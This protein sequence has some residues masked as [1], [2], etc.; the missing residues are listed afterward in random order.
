VKRL[1]IIVLLF[2]LLGFAGADLQALDPASAPATRTPVASA[3]DHDVDAVAQAAPPQPARIQPG[4]PDVVPILYR[5]FDWAN[6]WQNLRPEYGPVGSIHFHMWDEVNPAPGVYDWDVIDYWLAEESSL[7]VTLP[8]G[9]EIPKPVVIQVFPYI[10]SACGWENVFFYDGTPEWVYDQI[11]QENPSNPRPI[12]N[13]RKVGYKLEGCGDLV[14]VMPMYDSPTW[15]EA[16]FDLVRAFGERY[17]DHPQV[18][19]VVINTGLDGE[20]QPIKDF[21]CNWN[22]LLDTQLPGGVRYRFGQYL[23]QSMDVYRQAFPDK[24]IFINNAPGGGGTRQTT[25]DYAATFD[26]PIGLKHSGMWVDLDSHQGYGSFIGSWDMV[27]EYSQTLPIWL[28]SPYGFGSSEV[29][30]WALLAGLHYH[31]D[32]VDL[33]PDFF[34]MVPPDKLRWAGQH[35]GVTIQ[36]TPSIW[37]VLRDTE[38]PKQ[39]WGTGGVSG[40]MG[41]W[42]F[43]LYHRT[44]PSGGQSVRIWREDMPHGA[45]DSI[46]ARQARRTDEINNQRYMYFD[47]DDAYPYVGAKPIDE[48]GGNVSY[49]VRVIFVN[50]G[51][52]TLSLEYRNY[53]GEL[54][55]QTLQKGSNLGAADSW[56]DHTFTVTDGYFNNNMSG[57]DFR[58]SS[59]G[60]GNEIV[61]LV[62]VVGNWGEP[63]TPTPTPTATSTPTNTPTRTPTFTPTN[64]STPTNT[65]TPLSGAGVVVSDTSIHSDQSS[66]ADTALE[67]SGDGQRRALLRLDLSQIPAGAGVPSAKLRLRSTGATAAGMDV[68]VYG[69]RRAW[70]EA[71][72]TWDYST[73]G[74][75]WGLPGADDLTVDRDGAALASTTVRGGEVWYEWDITELVNAWAKDERPNHGLVLIGSDAAGTVQTFSSREGSAPPQLSIRYYLPT[76]TPTFTVTP[77]PGP[78]S[79]PT[80]TLAPTPTLLPGGSRFEPIEDTYISQWFTETN[81]DDEPLLI[82]RQGDI[83]A[84]LLEFDLSQLPTDTEIHDARL[85]LFVYNRTNTGGCYANLYKVRKDWDSTAATWKQAA[86]GVPWTQDGCNGEG[87]DRDQTPT[88]R[89]LLDD[90][91]AWFSFDVTELV[92]EWV[93][94]PSANHGLIIKGEGSVSVQYEFASTAWDDPVFW[95]QLIV[96]AG[97]IPPTPVPTA[98]PIPTS[99]FTPGPTPTSTV[100]PVPA[101]PTNTPQAP[102]PTKTSS[103]T[104]T[105]TATLQAPTATP[106]ATRDYALPPTETKTPTA[107]R[108]PTQTMTRTP[109]RTPT[110]TPTEVVPATPTPMPG[111]SQFLPVDDTTLNAWGPSEVLGDSELLLVRQG[112]IRTALLRFDLTAIPMSALVQSAKLNLFIDHRTNSGAMTASIYRV[113]RDWDEA[114]AN[115]N[116]A[117]GSHSWDSPGCNGTGDREMTPIQTL[118]LDSQKSWLTL[119]LTDLVQEWVHKPWANYGLVIK[120][121]G[122]ISVQYEFASDET[123]HPYKGPRLDVRYTTETPTPTM[124]RTPTYTPTPRPTQ[125]PTAGPSPTPTATFVPSPTPRAGSWTW[126]VDRDTFVDYWAIDANYG[127]DEVMVVRQGD[128]RAPLLRVSLEDIPRNENIVAARLHL[129]AVKRTNA[130]H[131]FTS[132]HQVLRHWNEG[133][134]NWVQASRGDF[135]DLAGCNQLGVDRAGDSVDEVTLDAEN[136]WFTF[137]VTEL[138]REW[139]ARP[140]IN[141][142]LVIKG[143]GSVSVQ[144]E[145]ASS[146]HPVVGARPWLEIIREAAT[147]T[148][149]RT[150]T[151]TPT[152]PPT[153]TRTPD[154]LATSTPVPQGSPTPTL[155]PM[156]V[157]T[158]IEAEHDASLNSWLPDNNYGYSAFLGLRTFGYKR[159]VFGFSL[160]SLPADVQIVRAVFRARTADTEGPGVPTDIIGLAQPW[161][162]PQVT[163]N[164]AA[165]G[166]AWH[167]PG[168]STVGKDRLDAPLDR[169][170]VYGGDRWWEWD[171]T[172]LVDDWYNGRVPN[173]GLMLISGEESI[174]RE[175]SIASRQYGAPAQLVVEYAVAPNRQAYT[176]QLYPGMNMISLPVAPDDPALGTLLGDVADKVVRVWAYDGTDM[177]APWRMYEPGNAESDLDQ[178]HMRYGY[179]IEMRE[180]AEIHLN[181]LGYEAYN[182][183]LIQGWNLCGYPGLT[184]RPMEAALGEI[185]PDV[186]VVWHYDVTDPV[187]PWKRYVPGAPSWTNTLTT[188]EPGKGYWILTRQECSL[189]LR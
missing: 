155:E 174:H 177:G 111:S 84:S 184:E 150:P 7:K 96:S 100:T 44:A 67:I 122:S 53:R 78:T 63:P 5:F 136:A 92:R 107:T 69:L 148:P 61:H 144:Y 3:P 98:T 73:S 149:T 38:Y 134:A 116:R 126:D 81:F 27:R 102:T 142:G 182:L 163:W 99:T 33:H 128:V 36:D 22:Y 164:H 127:D 103:P 159:P 86:S 58:I 130:G 47:M 119:D 72:A 139:V 94:D 121:S 97:E 4:D 104:A 64:T 65:P 146:E 1:G 189:I 85:N 14:A 176:L 26:P 20:T 169:T 34:T 8:D 45:R 80:P 157:H 2:V 82:M 6:D 52:D 186:R 165:D 95:P 156:T 9:T 32:A 188:F 57:S 49:L 15:R 13:D 124:T 101:T 90:E 11:D 158:V 87:T 10:S 62:E 68:R 93:A 137:D 118:T 70:D 168:A 145:F 181:G 83:V 143:S 106:Y 21:H 66:A 31:P 89:V 138:V 25:S 185:A 125:T 43:W 129:F 28:E 30:Y 71:T 16:Y 114:S 160:D 112:D 59:N 56:I 91:N 77:T 35:L 117:D 79:T 161:S 74:V 113:T 187:S 46:Y 110:A 109:T 135:W 50:H 147:P 23:L 179:W 41:D 105:S 17:N 166:I 140:E 19:S 171:V 154:P 180:A 152:S 175:V 123:E 54:V 141:H 172:A 40:H 60:D 76:S 29:K 173:H 162:E 18:T 108:T 115:W 151:Y 120:G 55:R 131:L 75:L 24:A 153:A 42:S 170:I 133:E 167:G 183:P 51:S 132:V 88:D 39:D 48:S 12:V 37:T 178:A